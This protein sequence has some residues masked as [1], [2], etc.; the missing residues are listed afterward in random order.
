MH[1]N[2]FVTDEY[3]APEYGHRRD[4]TEIPILAVP[5]RSTFDDVAPDDMTVPRYISKY[6]YNSLSTYASQWHIGYGY[7]CQATC[8]GSRTN[9]D[10]QG[11]IG[12]LW[13]CDPDDLVCP[14][15]NKLNELQGIL[16]A[17]VNNGRVHPNCPKSDPCKV[18]PPPCYYVSTECIPKSV[19]DYTLNNT[20]TREKEEGTDA[21]YLHTP[22][23]VDDLTKVRLVSGRHPL[24]NAYNWPY[25]RGVPMTRVVGRDQNNY[26]GVCTYALTYSGY[27]GPI[28]YGFALADADDN[29]VYD[30]GH[31]FGKEMW[32]R[33]YGET[34]SPALTDSCTI[35][36]QGSWKNR[37]V[38]NTPNLAAQN[39]VFGTCAKT[40]T[41]VLG[42]VPREQIVAPFGLSDGSM[43]D[44]LSR[45]RSAGE[46]EAEQHIRTAEV[47]EERSAIPSL[48]ENEQVLL[49]EHKT[50]AG[51]QSTAS[52]GLEASLGSSERS[53]E[54]GRFK[55]TAASIASHLAAAACALLI[56][57]SVVYANRIQQVVRDRRERL[58][59][60]GRAERSALIV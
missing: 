29:H 58:T 56:A 7:S 15:N 44:R 40:C 28:A 39:F 24:G 20:S 55:L 32:Q 8:A 46:S 45:S 33:F 27:S 42:S 52:V 6:D 13:K 49:P 23:E 3:S 47:L 60:E 50:Q 41:A 37:V 48:H 35:R 18:V 36:Q 38:T 2:A 17:L 53:H 4:H 5:Q 26:W 30:S 22:L 14:Q 21:D 19:L 11:P 16:D 54:S 10:V 9:L 59:P 31:I 51:K 25:S 43:R 57:A 12:Q 1:Y 34:A